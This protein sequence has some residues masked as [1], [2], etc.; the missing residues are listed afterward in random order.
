MSRRVAVA[1]EAGDKK[2]FAT[3]IDWPGWS[4]SGKTE[5]EALAALLAAAPRYAGVARRAKVEFMEPATTGELDVVERPSGN[6]STDF[7]VPAAELA[8]DTEPMTD[9][10]LARQ[11][12]LLEGSWAELDAVA[13][14]AAGKTLTKGPRGGGRDLDRII[15]HVHEANGA[16][17]HQLGTRAPKDPTASRGAALEALEARVHDKPLADPNK[18]KKP[19]TP[20]YFV[21]RAAW[22]A[23]DH[24]WEIEDRME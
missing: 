4:R 14:A 12:A 10:E 21:R 8:T 1:I 6:A 18:V 20:R 11:M 2:T 19:W 7:G 13:K 16:Y 22:H 3:A 17:V 5:E 23:L 24:T 9:A 15:D